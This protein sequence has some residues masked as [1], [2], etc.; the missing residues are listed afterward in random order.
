MGQIKVAE[1]FVI[2][3]A[4][5]PDVWAAVMPH[6]HKLAEISHGR[7]TAPD[8]VQAVLK[9]KTQLWLAKDGKDVS[10]MLTEI[11]GWPTGHKD[12]NIFACSGKNIETW[13]PLFPQVEA[14]ARANGCGIIKA[15]HCRPGF[16]KA[17]APL[18]FD[19]AHLVLEKRLA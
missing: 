1:L 15:D 16:K 18:G 12:A 3:V 19:E 17:L 11:I 5:P 6:V 13:L 4:S 8:I 14:W 7:L 2:T 10:V 9:G